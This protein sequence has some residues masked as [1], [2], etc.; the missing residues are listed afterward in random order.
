MLERAGS[1]AFDF[2]LHEGDVSRIQ[3][4]FL[5][6]SRM[7]VAVQLW[8]LP[9]SGT[10]GMHAHPEEQPLE[11]LYLLVEGTARMRV[12]GESF[13][14]EPG[15][16]VLAPVGAEHDFRNTGDTTVKVVVVWGRPGEADWS[17]FGTAKAGRRVRAE[18]AEG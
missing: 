2:R 15:D 3:W 13:D 8:E 16:A 6:Q 4:Y 5:D 14:M 11:E 12:D 7:P 17:P 10:E 1:T 9:P 18:G